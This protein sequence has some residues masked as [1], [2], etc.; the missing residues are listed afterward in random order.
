MISFSFLEL[1]LVIW[2]SLI[3]SSWFFFDNPLSN[4]NFLSQK[5]GFSRISLAELLTCW[6]SLRSSV[7]KFRKIVSTIWWSPGLFR[8]WFIFNFSHTTNL[9]LK[10][11]NS[12]G[13]APEIQTFKFW[14]WKKLKKIVFTC[15]TNK[16]DQKSSF[17]Y[18]K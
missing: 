18:R 15:F 12:N 5:I 2:S 13:C 7:S 10:I 9:K 6:H 4:L 17:H 14:N 1:F 3:Q 11:K 8:S 16:K